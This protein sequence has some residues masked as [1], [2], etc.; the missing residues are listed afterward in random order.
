MNVGDSRFA[1]VFER[2][3]FAIDPSH[4]RFQGTEG[5][6]ELLREGR[7]RRRGADGEDG[8]GGGDADGDGRRREREREK[9]SEKKREAD[10]N[11]NGDAPAVVRDR[12]GER[13]TKRAKRSKGSYPDRKS[14]SGSK[15]VK[16]R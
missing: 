11:D 5:M 9:G 7:K 6:R 15:K 16:K 10:S 8:D 4:P 13:D 2:P 12:K 3:E 1:D 14:I